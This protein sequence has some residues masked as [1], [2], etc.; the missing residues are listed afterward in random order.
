MAPDVVRTVVDAHVAQLL[1]G[2][3]LEAYCQAWA[4]QHS[5]QSLVHRAAAARAAALLHPND[6]AGAI[7]LLLEGRCPNISSLLY[8]PHHEGHL[9]H[10][11]MV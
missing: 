5:S 3:T 1:G 11:H 9:S 2:Q 7:S 10:S 4:Q 6:K 8:W